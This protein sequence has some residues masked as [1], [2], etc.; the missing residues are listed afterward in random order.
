MKI[1]QLYHFF[2]NSYER[3]LQLKK[4]TEKKSCFFNYKGSEKRYLHYKKTKNKFIKNPSEIN[5]KLH[6]MQC[7]KCASIKKKSIKQYFKSILDF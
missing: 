1:A 7:N 2:F 6:K 5:E 3:K 4:K